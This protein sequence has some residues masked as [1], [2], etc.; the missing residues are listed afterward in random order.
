MPRLPRIKTAAVKE[1]EE[2]ESLVRQL[3]TWQEQIENESR[4]TVY[5]DNS[6]LNRIL[7]GVLPNG[8]TGIV[9]S[10]EGVDVLTLFE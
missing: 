8:D 3:N 5:K 2:V 1:G 10:K 7:I 4:T 6:G 9:I